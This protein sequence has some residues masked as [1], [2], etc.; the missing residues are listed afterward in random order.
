MKKKIQVSIRTN[1]SCYMVGEKIEVF[2]EILNLNTNPLK[3]N[4]N[5][6]QYYD[7]IVLK[8][9]EEV[10]RWSTNKMFAMVLNSITIKAYGKE[11]FIETLDPQLSPGDYELIG[12]I[13][14]KP[15]YKASCLFKVK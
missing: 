2:I 11:K 12:I 15:S 5:S 7:L 14:S 8:D 10:W 13:N 3:L 9:D 1:K 6:T 4:F